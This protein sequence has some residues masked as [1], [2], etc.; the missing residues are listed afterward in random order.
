MAKGNTASNSVATAER[1]Y[2]GLIKQMQSQ[3][4]MEASIGNPAE[5]AFQM[6]AN[7]ID[8][9]ANATSEDEIFAANEA[10]SLPGVKEAADKGPLTILTIEIRKASEG[11]SATGTYIFVESVTD[12]GEP[13][14]WTVGAPNVATSLFRFQELGRI[15]GSNP[16]RLKIKGEQKTNGVLYTVIKP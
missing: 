8:R 3:A 7:A 1:P 11:K 14:D 9:I 13:F 16:I 12:Q 15:G 6:T 4:A 5:I 10:S 2:E